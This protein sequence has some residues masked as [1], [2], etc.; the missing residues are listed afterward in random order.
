MAEDLIGKCANL[1]LTDDEDQIVTL[2]GG[3]E[4]FQQNDIE[5]SIV[6][7]VYSERPYNFDAFKR[8]MTLIWAVPKGMIFRAIE[9][10]YFVIQFANVRDREK[11]LDGSP[12]TFDQHLVLLSEIKG[13]VQPSA[14]NI[15][16]CPFWLRMY[17]LPLDSRSEK[18][19]RT[20]AGSM[21]EILEVE[22]DEVLWDRS[23]RVRVL[24]DI[25]KPLRRL[26]R[27]KISRERLT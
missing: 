4:N 17:N 7:K 22:T 18:D 19:V 9:N 3:E 11:V 1:K 26:Q 21:G 14:I 10:G 25:T 5:L 13:S 15:T 27:I 8:T 24:L 6:G 16:H 23:A 12:W 2:K 20:I